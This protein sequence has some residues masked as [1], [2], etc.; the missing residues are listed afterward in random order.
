MSAFGTYLIVN[1]V[2]TRICEPSVG[3]QSDGREFHR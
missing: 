3:P 2:E 1:F